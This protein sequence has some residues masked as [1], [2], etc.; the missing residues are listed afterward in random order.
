MTIIS[1][2]LDCDKMDYLLRDS[3]YCGVEYGTYDL[4]KLIESLGVL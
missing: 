2:Q 3:H 4:D 1:G